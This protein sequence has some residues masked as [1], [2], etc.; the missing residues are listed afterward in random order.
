MELS[1]PSGYKGWRPSKTTYIADARMIGDN[2]SQENVTTLVGIVCLK[3]RLCG[4]SPTV[5]KLK[6][7]LPTVKHRA[8][9][10]E[11]MEHYDC[12][13]MPL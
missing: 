9:C 5:Q 1:Q 7:D 6:A 10:K 2:V 12:A 8:E 4:L 3:V 13:G 11:S